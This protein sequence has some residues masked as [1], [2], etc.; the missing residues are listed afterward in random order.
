MKAHIREDAAAAFRQAVFGMTRRPLQKGFISYYEKLLEK[1]AGRTLKV[2]NSYDGN[3]R[4][5][6]EYPKAEG[7]VIGIDIP[8]Y[9]LDYVEEEV[10][11]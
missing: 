5:V 11:P 1:W 8:R 4:Y 9:L 2:I 6:L 10:K 7:N 3:R